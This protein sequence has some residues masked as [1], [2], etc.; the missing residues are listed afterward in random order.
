MIHVT[1]GIRADGLS[2][3][4]VSAALGL[5]PSHAF[6][7]GQP[8]E[9]RS[10]RRTRPFGVWQLRSEGRVDAE[11][12]EGHVLFLLGQLEPRQ[13]ALLPYLE[14]PACYVEFR[15]WWEADAETGGFA[16]PAG[17]LARMARLCKEVNFTFI[18]RSPPDTPTSA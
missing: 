11:D 16:I 14:D 3:E 6:R 7:K 17:T 12:V 8:Y 10:G 5:Q 4:A 9:S 2:P 18:G 1:F 13:A 15:V